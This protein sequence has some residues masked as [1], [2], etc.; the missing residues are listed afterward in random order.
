MVVDQDVERQIDAFAV[1]AQLPNPGSLSI[2]TSARAAYPQTPQVAV[3]DTPFHS[4]LPP[5]AHTFAVPARLAERFPI[6]R[7]GFHGISCESVLRTA[8]S[9]LDKPVN[10]LSLIICDLGGGASVTAV[11]DG[12]SVDT[13]MG[14]TPQDG[15][16]MGTCCGDIDP[17]VIPY[18]TQMT[19]R[20]DDEVLNLLTRESGSLGLCGDSDM[21]KVRRRSSAGDETARAALAVYTHRVR[22]YLGAY[23][24]QLPNLD[25]LV[26]T[27]VRGNMMQL[28]VVRSCNR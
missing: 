6:R 14:M 5:D 12:Q 21:R 1:L 11:R 7:F 16:V 10:A 9:F 13:S 22:H 19:S 26:F 2:I 8:S 4:T 18:L 15:L 3:F 28:C 17:A 20:Q 25:A 27:G 24:A 23:I